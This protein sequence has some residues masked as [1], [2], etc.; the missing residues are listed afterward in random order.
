MPPVA[1]PAGIETRITRLLRIR[2]PV[3]QAGMVWTAGSRLAV[4][5]SE[6]GGLGMIGAGSMKPDLLRDHIRKTRA[7]TLLPFAVNIPLSRGDAAELVRTCIDE[8]VRIVFTSAGHP[9]KH[10]P[11]LKEHGCVVVHVAATVKHAVKVRDAGCDAVVVEG[12]EAGGHNGVDE[13]TTMVLVP[14]VAD[15]VDIPVIAAGGIADGRGLAAALALGADGVQ[16]GTRFAA[17]VESSA[18]DEYKRAVVAARDTDTVLTLRRLVPTRMLKSPFAARA[19]EAERRGATPEELAI[20]LGEGRERL[21]I[22]SGDAAEGELEAGQSA[23]LV[24]EILPAGEVVRRMVRE[25]F[26]AKQ[27]LP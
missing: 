4:A 6:A 2:Y 16:V 19:V 18:H 21:G 17:T 15:A 10:T 20:L 22:F 14:Q 27:G 24:R 8:E 13:L 11:L 26:E 3:I 5:V 12:F 23:G 7:A 25:Y 9:A 1:E